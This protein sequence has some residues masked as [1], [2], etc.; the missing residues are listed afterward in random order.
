V[1]I[2]P[3]SMNGDSPA[4]PGE[5]WR[6]IGNYNSH[7]PQHNLTYQRRA[8]EQIQKQGIK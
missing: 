3:Q 4:D 7:T 5:L 2:L 1:W 6:H 8:W